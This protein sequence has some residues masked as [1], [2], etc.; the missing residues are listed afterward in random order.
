[1]KLTIIFLIMRITTIQHTIKWACL[2]L[3]LLLSIPALAAGPLKVTGRVVDTNGEVLIGVT[4]KEKGT[5]ASAVTDINGNYTIT[6]KSADPVL[7]AQYVGF[8]P[9]ESKVH[10]TLCDMIMHEDVGKL[11]EVV[12][13]GYTTSKKLSVLGA[14]STLK[15][16]QVKAPVANLSSVLAGRVSGVMSVQRTGARRWHRAQLQPARP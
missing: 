8:Q 5:D 3:T 2:L 6:C 11:D 7:T 15:M 4:I 16:D 10:G 13:T 12:V 9:L 1:M 14:Q